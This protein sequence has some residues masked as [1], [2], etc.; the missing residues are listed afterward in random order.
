M[1]RAV[2]LAGALA[3]LCVTSASAQTVNTFCN[4]IGG[5]VYC[6][7]QPVGSSPQAL[8]AMMGMVKTPAEIQQ[9]IAE[10][11][12]A[13]AAVQETQARAAWL[14]EQAAATQRE[15]YAQQA[16][17]Q[18]QEALRQQQAS[19]DQ[20]RHSSLESR[21]RE[22]GS[23]MADGRCDDARKAALQ[24]GDFDLAGRVKDLCAPSQGTVAAPT[25]RSHRARP[26]TA[27]C[28]VWDPM[29]GTHPCSDGR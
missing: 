19:A 12:R 5:S 29:G 16:F 17:Q 25:S 22:I 4:N 15:N 26:D 21:N 14:R 3:V 24:A 10:A 8:V 11:E 1:M 27:Q 18:Q 7:S 2:T 6:N 13:R 9:E 20:E 28:K 23:L